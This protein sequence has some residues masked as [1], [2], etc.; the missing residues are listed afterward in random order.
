MQQSLKFPISSNFKIAVADS[1]ANSHIWNERKD[2][3][4]FQP[5]D[6]SE[7]SEGVITTGDSVTFPRELV[8]FKHIGKMTME[9]IIS[10]F[11][12]ILFISQNLQ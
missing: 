4:T 2:F 1:S 12:K 5:I 7:L 8:M 10:S 9:K 11:S 6:R 3:K